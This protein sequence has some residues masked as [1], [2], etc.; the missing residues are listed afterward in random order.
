PDACCCLR[1]RKAGCRSQQLLQN[2]RREFLDGRAS[3]PMQSTGRS[4]SPRRISGGE[5]FGVSARAQGTPGL[6]TRQSGPD[7]VIGAAQAGY[8][9]LA[10]D[11]S[12]MADAHHQHDQLR[13]FNAVDHPVVTH[14]DAPKVGARHLLAAG[15]AGSA[16]SA[17]IARITRN[18][19]E[20]SSASIFRSAALATLTTYSGM[21][22]RYRSE[23]RFRQWRSVA[24]P[25]PS[26]RPRPCSP[27]RC[28]SGLRLLRSRA[29]DTAPSRPAGLPVR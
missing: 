25:W 15:R 28:R 12:A 16:L 20:P 9:S 8:G 2:P 14:P 23:Q 17:W 18:R 4:A 10:V 24:L 21:R 13:V 27:L 7:G 5:K 3:G 22:L 6:R 1:A 19:A 11:F 29:A 26:S